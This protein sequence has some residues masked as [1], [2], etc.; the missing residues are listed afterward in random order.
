MKWLLLLALVFVPSVVVGQVSQPEGWSAGADLGL[1]TVPR[2]ITL[3]GGTDVDATTGP[4]V[5]LRFA[6]GITVFQL[7]GSIGVMRAEVYNAQGDELDDY[8]YLGIA[9]AGARVR[10]PGFPVYVGA[11]VAYTH[12][13]WQYVALHPYGVVGLQWTTANAALPLSPLTLSLEADVG[14]SAHPHR[15][16]AVKL[17]L[18]FYP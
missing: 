9:D 12:A 16:L 18:D 15:Y 1:R 14:V 5:N 7:F 2:P 4:A 6:Y 8:Q 17:G 10:L 13:D 3:G 11:G